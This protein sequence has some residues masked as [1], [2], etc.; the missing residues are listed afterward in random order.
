MEI[1]NLTDN[2]AEKLNAQNYK[3]MYNTLA[4]NCWMKKS[5]VFWRFL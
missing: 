4:L 5:N 2:T 3:K 1:S